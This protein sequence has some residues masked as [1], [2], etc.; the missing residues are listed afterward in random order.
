MKQLMDDVSSA[1]RTFVFDVKILML[2]WSS[3]VDCWECCCYRWRDSTEWHKRLWCQVLVALYHLS[4]LL[5]DH[6]SFYITCTVSITF[7]CFVFVS[8]W[9]TV[10][11]TLIWCWIDLLW[12]VCLLHIQSGPNVYTPKQLQITNY[13]E[14]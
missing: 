10:F 12:L 7:S 9:C 1:Q 5:R 14:K 2:P 4:H 11:S 3:F 13:W 8:H 6:F